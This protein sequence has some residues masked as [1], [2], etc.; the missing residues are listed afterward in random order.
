V[1]VKELMDAVS[2]AG[3]QT[4]GFTQPQHHADPAS[5]A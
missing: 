1:T 5:S 2:S 3:Y 4:A